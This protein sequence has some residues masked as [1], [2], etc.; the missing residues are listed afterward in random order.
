MSDLI[1]LR[2]N[3]TAADKV[4][5]MVLTATPTDQII[6]KIY[7][8]VGFNRQD[9]SVFYIRKSLDRPNIYLEVKKKTKF[10]VSA[11]TF[12]PINTPTPILISHLIFYRWICSH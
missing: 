8:I 10:E 9:H 11:Q 1:K 2:Y 7:Q 4:S 3:R 12:Y 6:D 5:F